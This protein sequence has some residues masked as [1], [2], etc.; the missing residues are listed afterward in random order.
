MTQHAPFYAGEK[1]IVHVPQSSDENNSVFEVHVKIYIKELLF[2]PNQMETTSVCL[3][4]SGTFFPS[5]KP[6]SG[7]KKKKIK[8]ISITKSVNYT[9][10]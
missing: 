2:I 5:Q 10:L 3:I 1:N 7:K 9:L 4:D 8:R 6:V